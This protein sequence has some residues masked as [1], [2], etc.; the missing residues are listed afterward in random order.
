MKHYILSTLIGIA[1]ATIPSQKQTFHPKSHSSKGSLPKIDSHSTNVAHSMN[2]LSNNP[3]AAFLSTNDSHSTIQISDLCDS[4]AVCPSLSEENISE[5]EK[6]CGAEACSLI[7]QNFDSC[8]YKV[9]GAASK[10]CLQQLK[11]LNPKQFLHL[12]GLDDPIQLIGKITE[13]IPFLASEMLKPVNERLDLGMELVNKIGSVFNFEMVP[14]LSLS[15]LYPEVI[16]KIDHKI[17]LALMI[18]SQGELFAGLYDDER[19]G[20]EVVRLV[21]PV[22]KEDMY[23]D[24]IFFQMLL[25]TFPVSKFSYRRMPV[26]FCLA[27]LLPTNTFMQNFEL[28]KEFLDK[29]NPE[30]FQ[31][32]KYMIPL[33]G[34]LAVQGKAQLTGEQRDELP[35]DFVN[36]MMN[37]PAAVASSAVG[38]I[39]DLIAGQKN[40]QHATVENLFGKKEAIKTENGKVNATKTRKSPTKTK[41]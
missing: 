25:D 11:G 28:S 37:N 4:N 7:M 10:E 15:M 23:V 26:E 38:T 12:F 8:S 13:L 35:A 18:I 39:G 19:I 17:L 20:S 6:V 5:F 2:P 24:P 9:F 14:K 32:P 40:G 29:I 1:S 22:Y 16:Q 31:D 21:D 33:Y 3:E 30:C 36:G 34:L 41:K 27:T